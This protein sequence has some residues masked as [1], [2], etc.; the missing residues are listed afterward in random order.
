MTPSKVQVKRLLRKLSCS[1]RRPLDGPAAE[2][3]ARARQYFWFHSVD[4][5]DR[6]GRFDV[7]LFL[8]VFYHLVDPIQAL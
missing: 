1:W 2:L 7:V 4:T 5:P 6:I 8:G 3:L